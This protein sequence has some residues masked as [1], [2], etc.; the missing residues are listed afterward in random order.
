MPEATLTANEV[1]QLTD[2]HTHCLVCYSDLSTTRG[3]TPCEHDD[4]CG[5]CHLRLRHLH[6]NRDCPI[7]KTTNDVIIVDD[8]TP[9]KKFTQYPMWGNDIGPGFTFRE[10]VGMFFPLAYYQTEILPLFGYSCQV[11]DYQPLEQQQQHQQQ[12]QQ[13]DGEEPTPTTTTTTT[14]TT[15]ATATPQPSGNHHKP[16]SALRLLQDHIRTKHRLALC[17]LCLENKR[18]FVARLPR[19][20]PRQLQHHLQRGD[21]A[22]SG[23]RGHPV[24]EFCRPTR[25]YDIT[26]LHAHLHKDH[27]L[28]HV[29]DKQGLQNQYFRNYPSLEKHF[30][31]V[32]YLCHDVQCLAARFVVFDNEIDL[33]GH[34]LTVHGGTSTGSTKIKLEFR[35][36]PSGY[37]GGGGGGGGGGAEPTTLSDSDF[38][39]GLDGQ[40]F[41]PAALP[42]QQHQQHHHQ[43]QHSAGTAD[44]EA[45]L[46]PLHLQRTQQLREQ[47]ALIRR[48]QQLENQGESFPTLQASNP[49]APNASTAAPLR[50]GWTSGSTALQRVATAPKQKQ[51]QITDDDFPSLPTTT[52]ASKSKNKIN[53]F[54][55]QNNKNKTTQSM[56]THSRQFA[57]M[58]AATA[59]PSR[60][61][62]PPISLTLLAQ[63]AKN[64]QPPT[65][66]QMVDLSAEQF[67]SLAGA[68]AGAGSN[69]YAA[70]NAL[71]KQRQ[72][73]QQQ[74]QQRT[75]P[76]MAS[77]VDFPGLSSS[78]M[79]MPLAKQP[80]TAITPPLSLD[81]TIDFPPPPSATTS[82][83]SNLRQQLVQGNRRTEEKFNA[84]QA[85][86]NI[87]QAPTN[88]P[89]AA[90]ATVEEI[91]AT[92]GPNK[93]KQ[94]K[95]YTQDFA[96]GSLSPEG[97]VDQ[98]AA[99]F[100][101][102]YGDVDFWNFLPLLIES[103]PNTDA[104]EHAERYMQSLQRQHR[105]RTA[106][107]APTTVSTTTP[108]TSTSWGNPSALVKS[109][110]PPSVADA[111]PRGGP[112]NHIPATMQRSTTT[113]TAIT[114]VTTIGRVVPTKNAAKNAW[115]NA[116]A[117]TVVRLSAPPGSVSAA[118]GAQQPQGGTATKFMAKQQKKQQTSMV[119]S[120]Q[121]N[122][123]S[124]K[125]S[126]NNNKKSSS[127]AELKALAFGK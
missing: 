17:S 39:Y 96:S 41:V 53:P 117:P 67:P 86:G 93:Y 56:T 107:S 104:A 81:S 10:D 11:C 27:Y 97:Y 112:M 64:K 54:A 71:A 22:E 13:N 62:T 75:V 90:K 25:F 47:A 21:G 45:L 105:N 60:L 15:T 103:C 19:M 127:K 91:K 34:E 101:L 121:A 84:H 98:S 5:I 4:I 88:R 99:L 42:S 119:T 124:G 14:A 72:Q 109:A 77:T 7:C 120:Q 51:G 102:G 33:R 30:D 61:V 46:H 9:E 79:K 76:S 123:G 38:N 116:G 32:H 89:T 68:G 82:T 63:P 35:V 73:Q 59:P 48:Q 95:R 31:Q 3:K 18:D 74:Q 87:L 106:T 100:D 6:G 16:K 28:C 113:M 23:F 29:C 92:L 65:P 108:S 12:E 70:A 40:A 115:G 52:H 111:A 50:T 37:S 69:P 44:T 26:Q 8:D 94:L 126:S 57:A 114:P 118:A 2:H 1:D 24:C 122:G 20:T 55:S 36:R 83:S 85:H 78:N 43:Q 49:S 110:P 125:K 66:S 58:T 80:P